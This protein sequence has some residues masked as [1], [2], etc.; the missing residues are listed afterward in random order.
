MDSLLILFIVLNVINVILQTLRTIFT[1][2]GNKYTA[3]LV[4]AVAFAFYTIII[5][6]TMCDLPLIV[7]ALV[8][9]TVNLIGVF[10]VKYIEEIIQKDK[11]WKIEFT[12]KNPHFF[13]IVNALNEFKV[14][15][16]YSKMPNDYIAFYIFCNTRS[17]S[18]KIKTIINK[19]EAKYFVS[20]SKSL[21]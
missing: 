10:T 15:Y 12:V 14:P 5:V 19:F 1:V 18:E 9:G 16:N 7:K 4:S 11:L 21:I 8:V 3:S 13:E 6:Y 2:N 17:E 20:E